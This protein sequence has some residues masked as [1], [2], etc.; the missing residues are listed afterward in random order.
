MVRFWGWLGV[1]VIGIVGAAI[2]V[3]AL[4]LFAPAAPTLW[5]LILAPL[6]VGAVLAAVV[7]R[8]LSRWLGIARGPAGGAAAVIAVLPM[9]ALLVALHLSPQQPTAI[10]GPDPRGPHRTLITPAGSAIAWWS[11]APATPRHR[12]PV[13]FL[14]G[15]PGTFTRN[16]DFAAGQGLRDAGFPTVYYDQSGS[17]ASGLLP[18]SG[19]TVAR[20]VADLDALRA[21]LGAEKIVV[22]GES[23]GA[24]LAAAYVRAHP[25]R[26]AATIVGSP[27]DFPGE[28]HPLD[29]SKT[30]SDGGFQPGL[31]D[32]A[33]FLLIGNAP[34]LA[35][36]WQSQR[37]AQAVQQARSGR[38]TFIHGYQ[39]KGSPTTLRR[40]PSWGGGNLYPQLLL[41]DDLARQPKVTG[42][43]STAPALLV[44]G[45][46]DYLPPATAARYMRAFP[47][48]QRID[49][50]GRGHAFFGHEDETS[51]ILGHYAGTALSGIM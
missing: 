3:G 1:A 2:T 30:D 41:Q 25:D 12:T 20:A 4:A 38:T 39:C 14:H 36:A 48:A 15:G 50:P 27:G 47:A 34:Q 24:S 19:Y 18:M 28:P 11:L 46:C 40:P 7:A 35:E 6:V 8:S 26:V 32:A 44:R 45:D 33:L 16:R 9:T 42:P 49:V 37:D 51:A 17:G 31:R 21:T 29:Y 22:W 5:V 10:P 23:W 43:L 13:I